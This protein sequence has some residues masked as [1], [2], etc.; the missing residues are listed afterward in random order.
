MATEDGSRA[1][2]SDPIEQF[3]VPSADT[4]PVAD[5]DASSAANAKAS[6]IADW[7]DRKRVR[8]TTRS[9]LPVR[10]ELTAGTSCVGVGGGD[11]MRG[12]ETSMSNQPERT[13]SG[14]P[15]LP[16]VALLIE[17]Q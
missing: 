7:F 15:S 17:T 14:A 5:A 1:M 2:A 6:R 9:R 16:R 12:R 11:T 3:N 8:T 13:N 4:H 10:A